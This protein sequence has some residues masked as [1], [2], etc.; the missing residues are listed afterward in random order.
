MTN[1]TAEQKKILSENFTTAL[2]GLGQP[3]LLTNTT[4]S[5]QTAL[6]D[7][8]TQLKANEIGSSHTTI[9]H[10]KITS[11]KQPTLLSTGTV[12]V[13][14][15]TPQ[16]NYL[17]SAIAQAKVDGMWGTRDAASACPNLSATQTTHCLL[18]YNKVYNA[19]CGITHGSKF[20]CNS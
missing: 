2:T 6:A 17:V 5:L 15:V 18:I 16:A 13:P 3:T 9:H 14:K 19:N 12:L 1:Y 20:A 10:I 8:F 11:S 7:C 4:K